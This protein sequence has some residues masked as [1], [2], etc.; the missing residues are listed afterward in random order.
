[1]LVFFVCM[2]ACLFDGVYLFCVESNSVNMVLLLFVG[3][4]FVRCVCCL[5]VCVIVL[6][7][8]VLC[9]C[10]CLFLSWTLLSSFVR[11][12]CLLLFAI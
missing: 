10:C 8:G 3:A 11:V 2:L 7:L 6:V 12:F 5:F 4:F 9:V 1:M